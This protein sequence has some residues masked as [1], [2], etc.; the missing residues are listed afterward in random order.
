[1]KVF[2]RKK[3]V[4][5]LLLVDG[6][7]RAGKFLLADLLVACKNVEHVQYFGLF[8]HLAYMVRMGVIEKETSAAILQCQIDNSAYD[9]MVGRNLN[10]RV[11][12]KSSIYR[13]PHLKEYLRRTLEDDGDKVTREVKKRE[14]YF[15]YIVHETLPNIDVYLDTYPDLRV[16]NIERNPID[17]VYSWYQK[18]WGKRWGVDPI[19][20][21]MSFQGAEGP[22]PW[23]V[24]E[25]NEEWEKSNE[26][27]KIILAQFQ[28]YEMSKTKFASLTES[29]KRKILFTSYE[30]IITQPLV[31]IEA[32]ADFLD[33][34]VLP[35]I[36][37][38]MARENIPNVHPREK[39]PEKLNVIKEMAS[40]E[41]FELLKGLGLEYEKRG[42]MLKY[43]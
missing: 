20:F 34:G 23:F 24:Y 41:C 39:R 31:E 29:D 6:I 8:E 15:T 33:R 19:D 36:K 10:T 40:A 9:L 38:V 5:D 4:D 11:G 1:M 12:D 7:T 26:M 17:L 30:D 43:C 22:I 35:I 42:G 28:V 37:S 18:G 21:S 3:L 16:I 32:I 13:S 25:I 27:D 14:R 2:K